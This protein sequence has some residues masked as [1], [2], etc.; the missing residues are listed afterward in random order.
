MAMSQSSEQSEGSQDF[1]EGRLLDG[2]LLLAAGGSSS[3]EDVV[4]V[5]L[6]SLQIV[7]V[8]AEDL[9]FFGNLDSLDVSDNQLSYDTII[10]QFGRLVR[11]TK[12]LL[13]CNSIS[14]LNVPHGTLRLLETLDLSFNELHGDVLGQLAHLPRLTK[15]NLSS[16]CIS[17]VPP[18][19][20]L[21]GLQA[22]E[23]LS[24]DANDLVQFVQWRALDVLPRLRKLS[25][26][27]N[28]VKR[29]KDDTPDNSGDISYFPVLEELDLS[30]N[31][32]ARVSDLPAV[33]LFR[34]LR[35]LN[36]SDNECTR[37]EGAMVH[38]IAKLKLKSQDTKPWYLMGNGSH[39][40]RE[41]VTQPKLKMDRRKMRKIRSF[42]KISALG[43]RATSQLGVYDE[44]ANRLLVDLKSKVT[45]VPGAQ[46]DTVGR[47]AIEA[48]YGAAA[49]LTAP[50]DPGEDLMATCPVMLSDDLSEEELE[51]IFRE[52]R[53]AIDKKFHMPVEE[54]TSF[55]RTPPFE[56]T[57]SA[58]R[59]AP[60]TFITGG[61]EEA[62]DAASKPS[63]GTTSQREARL[64]STAA[65]QTP[66]ATPTSSGAAA[67]LSPA[68]SAA[69]SAAGA[70]VAPALA[71]LQAAAGVT[72][73]PIQEPGS[74]GSSAGIQR[75]DP[76]DVLLKDSS[77]RG[78][79][80]PDVGVRE[81]MK[82][83]RAASM[84]EHAVAA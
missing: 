62:A 16:N 8:A 72:L 24:L 40:R 20:E 39:V 78:R 37:V 68:A 84:S 47:A 15:L 76:L 26:A 21:Y 63:T 83:L 30:A 46:G 9:T 45:G 66:S 31:E 74:R 51:E 32:I 50:P 64:R 48:G 10:E 35:V 22:L 14:S 73:P 29:L 3:P 13:S 82:A 70:G 75:S 44:E 60:G 67:G 28:R 61:S 6:S 38:N 41:K 80:M 11:L 81:A 18:E 53:K 33:R 25:L 54:P 23:E 65:Q 71:A 27:S 5:N 19:E 43:T 1:V 49:F 57:A 59:N 36:L 52:R 42:S 69:S 77:V 7:D 55:M 4:S 17:S 58:G 2:F 34:A 12:L 79:M 56:T